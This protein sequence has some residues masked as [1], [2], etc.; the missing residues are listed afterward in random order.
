MIKNCVICKREFEVRDMGKGRRGSG[1]RKSK[2]S[3]TSMTC[4]KDCSK[5]Y[6]RI[7]NLITTRR[8]RK[9]I[10]EDD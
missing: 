1:V 5:T 4:S 10:E 7:Y 2:R 9:I 3:S 8:V 6:T